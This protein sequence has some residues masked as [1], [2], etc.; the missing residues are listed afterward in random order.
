MP[1]ELK[2]ALRYFR[3]RRK[4]LARFT[5]LVAVVGIAAGV[6]SLIIANALARGFSDEMQNKILVNTA[7]ITIFTN[8]G[9]EIFNWREIKENLEK[10]ENVKEVSATTYESALIISENAT[11]YAIL[12]VVQSPKS[13]VQSQEQ[14]ETLNL[15]PKTE[16][17]VSLGAKLAEKTNLKAGDE[18]EIITLGN[19]TEPERSSVLVTGI[20][21]TGL[22]EYD[23]SWIYISPDNFAKLNEQKE[24]TPTILSVSVKDI[25][26][27][28]KTAD[29][30]RASLRDSF[31]VVDW[32]EA[33]QP[34]FAAL[35]LER[36][37]ALAIISLIIF[38]AALNITTTLA[39]L[40][41]ERRLDIAILRTCGAKTKSLIFIFLIEGLFLGFIG[42]FFGVILGLLGCVLG[43]Y[44]KII[45]LSAEVYSLEFIPFRPH[46]ANILLI[47]CIAFL[48][49][50]TATIY[51][52]LKAS[53]IKPLENLRN[54]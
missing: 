40:V 32:Q 38:I 35:S 51:P 20:F 24:F 7:H 12:R 3:A 39:L 28:N 54:H 21:Q 33:N 44:F 10:L 19:Q 37:V 11:S 8:D 5:S 1:F 18:A 53:R 22:Y 17:E 2:L 50:L 15:K 30:I 6:A 34:L 41:N 47:I 26:N 25:Y 46:F 23:S 13:K 42:I 31:K 16:I 36:K 9:T 52:A 45:S 48:L 27:A 29:E 49:C 4:S 43:N 14:P